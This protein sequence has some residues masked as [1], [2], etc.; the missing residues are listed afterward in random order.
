MKIGIIGATGKAGS[1]I[2]KEAMDR[3]HEVTAIVRSAAKVK[4]NINILEKGIFD[5]QTS[6]IKDFDVIVNAFNTAPGQEKQHIEAGR[7]LIEALKNA[8]STRL[9]VVGGAG[10]LFVD[11]Q[12]T[13]RVSETPDFPAAFLP[14]A[15]NMG[16]NLKELESSEG[17]QW[18]YISPGG[19]FD[20]DGK[21]TGSYQTGGEVMILNK[22]GN[23]YISYADYAIAVLD[24][25]EKPAHLNE[26]FSVVG[27]K[28]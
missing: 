11:E 2:T 28:E 3:G 21:R 10:S 4:Q 24:E 5:I 12:K 17:I 16:E 14:T 15:T 13:T 20:A 23:S 18:T 19:F 9:L 7:I 8:P 1:L 6:D 25:I 27:E 26:R 22:Q